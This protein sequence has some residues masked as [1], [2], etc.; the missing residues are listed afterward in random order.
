LRLKGGGRDLEADGAVEEG[1]DVVGVQQ[2]PALVHERRHQRPRARR[3]HDL[4]LARS[5]LILHRHGAA[6][7]T[8]RANDD[9]AERQELLGRV[10]KD[11]AQEQGMAGQDDAMGGEDAAVGLHLHVGQLRRLEVSPQPLHSSSSVFASGQ[12]CFNLHIKFL[13]F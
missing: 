7:R 5:L 11:L 13:K 12:F 9:E 6:G 3:Q 2:D 10:L 1:Q 8:G 4:D